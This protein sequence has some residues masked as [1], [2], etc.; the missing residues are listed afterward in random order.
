MQKHSK[1]NRKRNIFSE[2]VLKGCISVRILESGFFVNVSPDMNSSLP[3]VAARPP[4]LSVVNKLSV[5]AQVLPTTNSALD[6][7][8]S[9][10]STLYEQ[11]DNNS[12]QFT[13]Q[14]IRQAPRQCTCPNGE[15]NCVCPTPEILEP[16]SLP[17]Q[18]K[19]VR[20]S[21]QSSQNLP[22][23]PCP[24]SNT[25]CVCLNVSIDMNGVRGVQ[26]R[27]TLYCFSLKYF[28]LL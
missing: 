21:P 20:R 15:N 27:I 8:T 4:D 6:S 16:V 14:E 12:F 18:S 24:S 9:R 2:E 28:H 11:S 5:M 22:N 3:P 19:L 13:I 26:R 25:N 23:C 10:Y 17:R 7:L 1:H